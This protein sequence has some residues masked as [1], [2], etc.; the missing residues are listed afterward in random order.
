MVFFIFTVDKTEE[1]Q[2]IILQKLKDPTKVSNEFDFF[3]NMVSVK[4]QRMSA[5]KQCRATV[6]VLELLEAIRTEE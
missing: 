3:G 1:I 5:D 6:A 2:N 4:I